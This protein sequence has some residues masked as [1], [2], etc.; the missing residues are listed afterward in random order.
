[1]SACRTCG[2]AIQWVVSQTSGK[3][4]PIDAEPVARGN[5][6]IVGTDETL[7]PVVVYLK[8]GELD[9]FDKRPR[10]VSHFATCPQ[11]DEHRRET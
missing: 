11:A 3:P 4:M 1:M 10:Y 8:R 2:A 6:V 9:E 5:V 7:T